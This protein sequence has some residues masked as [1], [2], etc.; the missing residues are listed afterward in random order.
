MRKSIAL[1]LSPRDHLSYSF[2]ALRLNIETGEILVYHTIACVGMRG[3]DCMIGKNSHV[4]R[5]V[6]IVTWD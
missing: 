6:V 3:N 4:L 2:N 1:L 5:G